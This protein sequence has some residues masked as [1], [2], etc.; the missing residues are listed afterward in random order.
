MKI[1][2]IILKNFIFENSFGRVD[3]VRKKYKGIDLKLSNYDD[4]S[5][6]IFN[7]VI[8]KVEIERYLEEKQSFL[9]ENGIN[10]N[11]SPGVITELEILGINT[12]TF[13][14]RSL[15]KNE[16]VFKKAPEATLRFHNG[17]KELEISSIEIWINRKI[18]MKVYEKQERTYVD[19][20]FVALDLKVKDFTEH[21]IDS[22]LKNSIQEVK[23]VLWGEKKDKIPTFMEVLEKR[24]IREKGNI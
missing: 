24:Y 14:I 8:P 23:K 22:L 3:E 17:E 20:K 21:Q 15:K 13:F 2:R 11:L 10:L 19:F 6:I 7:N 12:N 5:R 4:S 1:S 16:S 18:V 9:I